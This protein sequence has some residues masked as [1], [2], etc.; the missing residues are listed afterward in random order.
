MFWA[1]VCVMRKREK[2]SR[3][4]IARSDTSQ[5]AYSAYCLVKGLLTATA[6]ASSVPFSFPL[7]YRNP[8][9]DQP[10]SKE[11]HPCYIHQT[12]ILNPLD[13]SLVYT[14]SKLW[15][16]S[17]RECKLEKERRSAQRHHSNHAHEAVRIHGF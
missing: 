12:Q 3:R 7:R 6:L 10:R 9:Y 4:A 16:V 14:I 2:R 15:G 1:L 8:N 5:H 11:H 13:E 17:R